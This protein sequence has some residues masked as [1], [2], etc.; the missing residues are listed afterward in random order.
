MLFLM[1]MGR[2]MQAVLYCAGNG[3]GL[4]FLLPTIQSVIS[5]LYAAKQRGKAFGFLLT[6]AALGTC[7]GHQVLMP[8]DKS[9]PVKVLPQQSK[10][11]WLTL[12]FLRCP[13]QEGSCAA[14]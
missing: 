14:S 10:P 12:R 11:L 8:D 2:G 1:R 9:N 6:T 13:S 3:I 4:A 7:A 5:E